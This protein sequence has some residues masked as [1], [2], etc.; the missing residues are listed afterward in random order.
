MNDTLRLRYGT[1]VVGQISGPFCHQNTW[2]GLFQASTDAPS[3]TTERRLRDYIAFCEE[4][5]ARLDSGEDVDASDFDRFGD[6]LT[7][8]LWRT[9]SPGGTLRAIL[10]APVF[11]DGEVTWTYLP[12]EP[13]AGEPRPP[14]N[15][16]VDP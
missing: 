5:Q 8:G 7:S 1:I 10:E 11:H 6:V 16:G 4:W 12:G 9:E 15:E 14:T 3:D 2:F 13:G